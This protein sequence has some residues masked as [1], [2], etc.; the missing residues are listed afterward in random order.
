[1]SVDQLLSHNGN[2]NYV[3]VYRQEMA[4]VSPYM[5]Q[6]LDDYSLTGNPYE[7]KQIENIL[8]DIARQCSHETF[9]FYTRVFSSIQGCWKGERQK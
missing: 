6:L 8:R 9:T 1:M 4:S 3:D 5:D 7:E 2:A